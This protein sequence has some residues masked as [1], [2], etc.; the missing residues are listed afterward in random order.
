VDVILGLFVALVILFIVLPLIGLALWALISTIFVGLVIGALGRLVVPGTHRIGFLATVVSGLCGSIVGGFIGQHVL[1]VG[2]LATILL[3]IGVAAVIVAGVSGSR[4][5]GAGS[6]SR[7]PP[8][9]R[10]R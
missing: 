8:P 3:E 5:L 10:R 7:V 4:S 2:H 1:H 9:S 6:G